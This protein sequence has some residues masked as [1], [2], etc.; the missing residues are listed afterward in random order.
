MVWNFSSNSNSKLLFINALSMRTKL[1]TRQS[2]LG[3]RASRKGKNKK[4][5]SKDTATHAKKPTLSFGFSSSPLEVEELP[6]L[7]G[8]PPS[9]KSHAAL[10]RGRGKAPMGLYGGTL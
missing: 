10:R 2:A 5:K 8:T 6:P 9:T 4:D 3:S 1:G 7:T